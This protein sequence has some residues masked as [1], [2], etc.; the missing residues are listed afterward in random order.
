[1]GFS[2]K[3]IVLFLA[4]FLMVANATLVGGPMD[5][6]LN[7][8]GVKDALQMAVSEH[9][10]RSNDAYL[11]DVSSVIKVQKQVVS[12]IKYIFKVNMGRT[13]CRKDGAESSCAVHMDVDQ[14]KAYVCTFEVWSQPWLGSIK[15]VKDD[16][17]Q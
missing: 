13:A 9:N 8:P 17:K 10:K 7:E 2:W 5:A 12:G 15:M 4:V 6:N 1:M 11:R 14:A 3:A 16:C